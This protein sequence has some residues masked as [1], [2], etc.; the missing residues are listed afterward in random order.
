MA[1]GSCVLPLLSPFTAP[2]LAYAL[3]L[4]RNTPQPAVLQAKSLICQHRCIGIDLPG[5]GLSHSVL[6]EPF[7]VADALDLLVRT[8]R[9]LR[10]SPC[11]VVGHSLGGALAVLAEAQHPGLF[12]A[13]YCFEPVVT[14]AGGPG[15]RSIGNIR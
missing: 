6:L 15:S 13:I 14:V 11:Y 5:H 10:I 9:E 2:L 3:A 1:V 8:I 4:M 12:R 7:S